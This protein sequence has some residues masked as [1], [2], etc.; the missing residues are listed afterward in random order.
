MW[1]LG[2][3]TCHEHGPQSRYL[4]KIKSHGRGEVSA[5]DWEFPCEPNLTNKRNQSYEVGLGRKAGCDPNCLRNS[6]PV[7]Q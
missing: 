2:I 3:R 1:E 5:M 6:T 7:L 4:E